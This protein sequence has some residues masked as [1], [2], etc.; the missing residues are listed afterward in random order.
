[1]CN[2]VYKLGVTRR[3]LDDGH[4]FCAGT[5]VVK[6]SRKTG[7]QLVRHKACASEFDYQG[8]KAW[9]TWRREVI[10]ESETIIS[11]LFDLPDILPEDEDLPS[12]A[13][14]AVIALSEGEWLKGVW[15]KKVP[16]PKARKDCWNTCD[17]PS[18]CRWGKKYGV[19]T[20]TK[21]TVTVPSSSTVP[22]MAK[23]SFEDILGGLDS[24]ITDPDSP[25]YL[26]PLTAVS[27]NA[28]ADPDV[29][30][31]N[32]I[33]EVVASA[34]SRKRKSGSHI[35]SPLASN[36]LEATQSSDT[37]ASTEP[38]QAIS[39]F[40]KALDELD[41]EWR[42]SLTRASGL[43]TSVV[44]SLRSTSAGE[45]DKAGSFVQGLKITKKKRR[46]SGSSSKSE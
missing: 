18:E 33:D 26:E 40:S 15:T 16:A 20:P 5:T 29:N 23:T 41:M 6:R 25:D 21:P 2:R 24:S 45:E 17:Y 38:S 1:M 12:D 36:P 44:S 14:L 22:S 39:Q 19:P 37:P 42:K 35:P 43:V 13:S 8:W 34:K 30:S 31:Q 7:K 11:P 3:C 10:A 9:G 4:F 32:P 27:T 46:E 28:S